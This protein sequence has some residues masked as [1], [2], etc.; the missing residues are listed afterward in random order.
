MHI[1]IEENKK[2]YQMNE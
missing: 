2:Q 1:D